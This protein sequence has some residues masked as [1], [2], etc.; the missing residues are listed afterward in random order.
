MI[1]STFDKFWDSLNPIQLT[2]ISTLYQAGLPQRLGGFCEARVDDALRFIEYIT[3]ESPKNESET[4]GL[5]DFRKC[6]RDLYHDH[7]GSEKKQ[8]DFERVCCILRVRLGYLRI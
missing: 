1:F 7:T 5:L 3:N 2:I 8:G 6:I 4:R